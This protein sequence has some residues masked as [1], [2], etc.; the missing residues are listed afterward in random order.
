MDTFGSLAV[1]AIA[2]YIGITVFAQSVLKSITADLPIAKSVSLQF[3]F[4]AILGVLIGL[5]ANIE[6]EKTH[7]GVLISLAV[8]IQFEK[9]HLIVFAAGFVN[10]WGAYCQWQAYKSSLSKTSILSPLSGVIT[11]AL[12]AILLGEAVLYRNPWS[13]VGIVLLFSSTFFLIGKGEGVHLKFL[14]AMVTIFGVVT[15]TMKYFANSDI[16]LPTFLSLW[17]PGA[18]F[19][20]L[21]PLWINRREPGKLLQSRSWK[22]PLA[23]MGIIAS[24]AST[25]WAFQ[26]APANV[27]LPI[28]SFGVILPTMLV[29]LWYFKEKQTINRKEK[30]GF[31]L[32]FLGLAALV[33]ARQLT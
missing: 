24:L 8:N 3:L 16:P 21:I 13:L 22:I 23:S 7:P 14:L 2:S 12:A 25:Y 18:F 11:A 20:S 32:G 19:G 27:V 26:E 1:V 6:F 17:Y 28:T 15:F 31:L 10:A 5:A 29:G 30:V 33:A 9:T 4:A